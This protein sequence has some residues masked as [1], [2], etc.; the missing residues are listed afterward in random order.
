MVEI[1]KAEGIYLELATVLMRVHPRSGG[2]SY[3][4]FL[5]K[6]S[7]TISLQDAIHTSDFA[8][9]EMGI[10][11][12]G[13]GWRNYLD[14]KMIKI[15]HLFISVFVSI[16]GRIQEWKALYFGYSHDQSDAQL[17]FACLI[18]KITTYQFQKVISLTWC[19]LSTTLLSWSKISL[20][21]HN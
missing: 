9:V 12:S 2:S 17:S 6:K 18:R 10:C 13:M 19:T 20:P 15:I 3:T 7:I 1:Y 11:H 4:P 21:I 5:R 16:S 14:W 8:K